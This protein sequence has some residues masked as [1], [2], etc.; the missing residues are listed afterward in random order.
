MGA[1]RAL[2]L[3]IVA[4]FVIALASRNTLLQWVF[5]KEQAHLKTAY[6]LNLNVTSIS[7]AG[8]TGARL[9]DVILAPDSADTLARIKMIEF[10][11]SILSLL[12]GKLNFTQLKI[13]SAEITAF[14][15]TDH[16]NLG[17]LK[18]Y[19]VKGTTKSSSTGFYKRSEDLKD[20]L[21]KLLN[22]AVDINSLSICY[23]DTAF[24]ENIF[25]PQLHYDRQRL[26]ATVINRRLSDTLQLSAE[27]VKRNK[28]FKVG[29]EHSN[30][31][32]IYL[33]F[34]NAEHGLKCRFQSVT[35]D[36]ELSEPGGSLKIDEQITVS[37]FH[38]QHWRLAKEDV[39]F[40]KAQFRGTVKIKEDVFELD[41]SSTVTLNNTSFKIFSSYVTRPDT[42]FA[43]NIAMPETPSDTFFNALPGGMF[44]TL[45]GISC[46][47]TLAYNLQFALDTRQPDSL[48][49]ESKLSRK[50][51]HIIHYGEENYARINEPFLYD[52][53]SGDQFIRR[54]MVGSEN[55]A[56]TPFQRISPNLPA[57]ILQSEDP[58]FM[59]HRGF[60]PEA[61]KESIAKNYKEHRF[62]RGGSTISMQLVKNVFLNHNK[63]VSRKAEE[64]LIV[65]LIENLGL[66]PKERMLEVYLNVI[67]WGPNVYGVG[68]ASRFYFNKTPAELTLPECIFLA[69]IIPN[70][71][72]FRYQFDKQGEIKSY[73][74]DFFKLIEN[75]MVMRGYLSE[76]DTVNF[77]PR[78]KLN[79]PARQFVIPTD[80]LVPAE[81]IPSSEESD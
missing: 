65:Y 53:F 37:N 68:E 55:P 9:T 15:E 31:N 64:A 60:V 79:G 4:L 7:F 5:K 40:P 16:N 57:A 48:I 43:L 28:H 59:V 20:R 22:T 39:V 47:G 36:V 44:S 32:L 67:E 12:T 18:E 51:F 46:S 10:R 77:V 75:R 14:R 72:F 2:I 45:K 30:T 63:T 66:V 8:W 78:V 62:A 80:T 38:I 26:S 73:M 6:H 29:I 81:A 69:A 70:P 27:V 25:V 41:S 34:L 23:R 54:I 35:A 58:A 1:G 76:H 49:F 42:V 74:S 52:A 3:I 13:D 56:F 21:L 33:P 19:G 71:K 50:N 11:P 24:I 17:F 61:F